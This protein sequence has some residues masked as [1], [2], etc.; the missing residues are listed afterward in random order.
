MGTIALIGDSHASQWGAAVVVAARSK[1]WLGLSFT[2]GMCPVSKAPWVLPEPE[3]SQCIRW[4]RAVLC[5]LARQPKVTTMCRSQLAWDRPVIAR[6]GVG[7]FAAEVRGY[8]GG[9]KAFRRSVRHI[10]VIRA[11]PRTS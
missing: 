2:N 5:W 9:W 7:Q 8:V 6:L 4:S 3:L 11:V 1:L 10:V